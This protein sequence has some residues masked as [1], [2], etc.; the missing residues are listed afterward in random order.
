MYDT[1]E[2]AADRS[3]SQ[4]ETLVDEIGSVLGKIEIRLAPVLNS[5][6]PGSVKE[7]NKPIQE[8]SPLLKKLEDL[9]RYANDIKDRIVV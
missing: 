9:R 2:M 4:A 8:P 7:A 5:G 1:P 6:N 3:P